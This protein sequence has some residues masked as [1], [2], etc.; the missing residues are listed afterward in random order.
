MDDAKK[1]A[2]GP[3]ASE[4]RRPHAGHVNYNEHPCVPSQVLAVLAIRWVLT[5]IA[6]LSGVRR[7]A[8][9]AYATNTCLTSN[10]EFPAEAF[11]TSIHAKAKGRAA[12]AYKRRAPHAVAYKRRAPRAVAY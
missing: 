7:T 12:V 8:T 3:A 1:M 2:N 4:N 6:S 9:Y 10:F 11:S 5:T